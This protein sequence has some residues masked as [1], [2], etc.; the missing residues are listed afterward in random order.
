MTG[1]N[2]KPAPGTPRSAS[3]NPDRR[4]PQPWPQDR[5]F[6]ILS[7]DGGGIKGLFPAT[8]LGE[9]ER[10]YL[11]GV[12]IAGY[13]DLVA[14]T[15]T[16][17]I[18][19]LGLG[20][21]LTGSQ[22]AGLYL[23][24]GS[25][26]FPEASNIACG[27]LRLWWKRNRNFLL[28]NY[29]RAPLQAFLT[30]ALGSKLLGDSTVRLCVPAFD[31]RHSEVFVFKTPHHR[32]YKF[33][34]FDPMVKVGL[35]T[36]AA[37]TYFQPLEH[38]EYTLVDGGVWAN[39]PVMLAVIEALVCFDLDRDQIDVL[40]LG[41][42]DDPY[43]VSPLQAKLGGNLPWYDVIF[44]AMRL[45]SLSATNQA[46][47]LL[48]PPAVRRLDPPVN[49]VPIQLDDFGRS[50]DELIPAARR[51]VDDLG[52]DIAAKFLAAPADYYEPVAHET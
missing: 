44:A 46:R 52:D 11:G 5:R 37:P 30:E 34:R 47:L 35:A 2:E 31:G 3:A 19:A 13:F 33:D 16:G 18:L 29:E 50:R 25:E 45:Q 23:R 39:N 51:A 32:D 21:G 38:N 10:R 7:I 8:V 4:T 1:P 22:L 28:Y 15:S 20:A 17:G 36:A 27:R 26:I 14:G 9:L 6:R 49:P 24:R 12:S 41:C 43:V 42:G 48:G 40:S